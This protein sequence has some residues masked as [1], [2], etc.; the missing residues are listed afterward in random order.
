MDAAAR[1]L[2]DEVQ[3]A[4]AKEVLPPQPDPANE[5]RHLQWAPGRKEPQPRFPINL[6]VALRW[7]GVD[8]RRTAVD[9]S[10]EGMFVESPDH[11][12]VGEMVQ[13]NLRLGT[14]DGVRLLCSV[15]RVVTP[16]E[17]AFCGGMPGMG[18]RFFLMDARLQQTWR[19]Y[20]VQL[21]S[22]KA[23]MAPDPERSEHLKDAPR[24]LT[25]REQPRREGRFR[26]RVKSKWRLREFWTGDVSSGGLFIGTDKPLDPGSRVDLFVVHPVTQ[27]EIALEAVVR[28]TRSRKQAVSGPPGMGVQLVTDSDADHDAFLHFINEG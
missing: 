7:G 3:H 6:Q 8:R 25:R 5:P 9:I 10:D 14:G 16:D 23:P 28:W 1:K 20:L 13:L 4:S 11:Q 12:P 21:E 19:D 2:V 26:V 18:L 17:A 24:K 15:E 22:G 27:R